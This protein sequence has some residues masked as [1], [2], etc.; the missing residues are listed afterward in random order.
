MNCVDNQEKTPLDYAVEGKHTI[1]IEHDK[2]MTVTLYSHKNIP[3]DS[4]LKPQDFELI[5]RL[6]KGAFGQV[7]LVKKDGIYY[8]MKIMKKKKYN[9]LL[10]L[11]LTEKEVQRKVKHKF[12]V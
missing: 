9:G 5:N 3:K 12:I 1:I 8:A 7:N 11:V 2:R 4:K 10:N 6:G